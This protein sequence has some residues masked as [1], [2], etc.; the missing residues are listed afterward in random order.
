MAN[1][2]TAGLNSGAFSGVAGL[3]ESFEEYRPAAQF[4]I[5][6][7]AATAQLFDES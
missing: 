7:T 1:G 2:M 4:S 3:P 6:E 5:D